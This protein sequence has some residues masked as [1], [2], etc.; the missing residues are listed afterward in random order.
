MAIVA[1]AILPHSPLLLPGLMREV[2]TQVYKITRAIEQL[3][4][5]FYARQIDLLFLVANHTPDDYLSNQFCLLQA[6]QLIY[7]FREFG[8][9]KTVGTVKIDLCLTHLIRE[10]SEAHLAV[11]L[12]TTKQLPYTFAVP[13]ALLSNIGSELPLVC[14]QVPRQAMFD[15]LRWLASLIRDV[16]ST[17]ARRVA[18]VATG[19]LAHWRK[20]TASEAEIFDRQF[21]QAIQANDID[22]LL[23]LEPQLIK[24]SQECLVSPTVFIYSLLDNFALKTEIL[25][26]NSNLGV[27]LIVADLAINA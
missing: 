6:P 20:N 13:V 25:S 27:G 11:P 8:D 24:Q 18:L 16:L 26:Y 5:E 7:R 4:T 2:R 19:D 9:L 14:L 15:E 12:I 23:N 21:C 10:K 3:A 22:K 1:A 17:E